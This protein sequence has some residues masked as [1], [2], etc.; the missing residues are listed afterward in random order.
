MLSKRPKS[1]GPGVQPQGFTPRNGEYYFSSDTLILL[2]ECLEVTHTVVR[3]P[4][5]NFE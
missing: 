2:K 1:H 5:F 3:V 4:S